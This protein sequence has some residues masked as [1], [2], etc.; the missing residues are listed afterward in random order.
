MME[1]AFEAAYQIARKRG[2]FNRQVDLAI[3]LTDWRFYG[4]HKH[5]PMVLGTKPDRGTQW[6]YKFATV[7]A[8]VPGMRFCL[9]A[10][11]VG[12]FDPPH[13]VLEALL[14]YAKQKV[15]VGTVYLDRGFYGVESIATLERMGVRWLMP[16][17]QNER[18][19]KVVEASPMGTVVDFSMR[20]T[21][22]KRGLRGKE[23]RFRLAVVRSTKD[24]E[25]KVSF[26]TNLPIDSGN[27]QVVCDRYGRRWG[28][29][30]SFR[31]QDSFI[32]KTTSKNYR[33]RLFYFMW[34]VCLYNLWVL[35]NIIV[36]A[37]L[38]FLPRKP[39]VTAK[40]FGALLYTGF[41]FDG[42]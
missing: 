25:R 31:V 17:T 3:D 8:V 38:W 26:A 37:V 11:P 42:G 19:R 21:G 20:A 32:A 39:V 40:M 41:K 13:R 15:R 4:D 30:T 22:A 18:V 1:A 33:V 9:K 12:Q 5:T 28:I 6:A 35:A 34:S 7:T 2:A 23:A 10:I 29:E 36:G 14:T 16:A 27:V 24:P